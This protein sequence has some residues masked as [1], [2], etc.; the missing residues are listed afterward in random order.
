MLQ[1]DPT[2]LTTN[3]NGLSVVK[4]ASGKT[5]ETLLIALE[6][7]HTFPEHTSPRDALLV[8]LEGDIVFSIRNSEIQI[9]KHQ[10]FKFKAEI[11]HTVF[12]N[13]NSKFLIIR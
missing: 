9:K 12:A 4:L 2:I 6:K 5:C 1:I 3:Y 11:P 7:G 13:A 8:V 10:T